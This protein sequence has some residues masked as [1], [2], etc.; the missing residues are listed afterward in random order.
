VVKSRWTAVSNNI[1]L[2]TV[3]GREVLSYRTHILDVSATDLEGK[4]KA[5]RHNFIIC[6]FDIPDITFI[7]GYS[8]LYNV[9]LAISFCSG[10]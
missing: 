10:I 8:W 2:S 1:E 5:C 4:T 7:L 3:D 9:D 6:E